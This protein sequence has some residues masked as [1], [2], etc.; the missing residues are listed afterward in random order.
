MPAQIVTESTD[1]SAGW[2]PLGEAGL[3]AGTAGG[4]VADTKPRLEGE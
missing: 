3:P 1:D 2:Q 4:E